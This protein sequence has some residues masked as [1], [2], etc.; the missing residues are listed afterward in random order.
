MGGVLETSRG[1]ALIVDEDETFEEV[2]GEEIYSTLDWAR[3]ELPADKRDDSF[4]IMSA[5]LVHAWV[6]FSQDYIWDS[7][8]ELEADIRKAAARFVNDTLHN[9]G[10]LWR[11]ERS[12]GARES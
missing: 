12:E 10:M 6:M 5:A 9:S 3:D 11:P 8:D 7:R 4:E 1:R 2:V